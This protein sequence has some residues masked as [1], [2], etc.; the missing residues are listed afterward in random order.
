MVAT[1]LFS[2]A[3]GS[4]G[5]VVVVEAIV[6]APIISVVVLYLG[7]D[8]FSRL[9]SVDIGLVLG[10]AGVVGGDGSPVTRRAWRGKN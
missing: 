1:L 5:I 3:L 9:G 8:P 10:R 7:L 2:V 6:S 4:G